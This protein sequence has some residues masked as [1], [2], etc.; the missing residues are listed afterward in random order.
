LGATSAIAQDNNLS[1]LQRMGHTS[2]SMT[3]PSVPQ[4][5][6]NADAIRANL[7][8]V[9][10]PDG[11]KIDLYAVVP[12][13]RYMAVAPSTNMLFVGTRKTNVYAVTNRNNGDA[14]TDVKA[15]AP[16]IKFSNPNG[17]YFTKD[18]FLIEAESNRILHFPAAEYFYEGPDVA[19]GV[20]V[21]EGKLIPVEEQS[22]NHTGR[23]CKVDKDGKILSAWV[24][25]TTSSLQAKLRCLKNSASVASFALTVWTAL[26]A[27]FIQRAC[28]TLLACPSGPKATSGRRTIRSTAWGMTFPQAS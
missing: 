10:L 28:A 20:I 1:T 9:K 15:F 24:S 18:G 12:D 22:F 23:V 7:K 2:T 14:A 11:F 26:D 4:E 19:V 13:A 3:I 6:K 5:G 8:K 21:P 25:L 17:V 27:R 16:S